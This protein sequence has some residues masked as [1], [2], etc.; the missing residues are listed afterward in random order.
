MKQFNHS[1]RACG[2][3][4]WQAWSVADLTSAENIHSQR[5]AEA[6]RYRPNGAIRYGQRY[7][8]DILWRIRK[9]ISDIWPKDCQPVTLPYRTV[10]GIHRLH[11]CL[12][13]IVRKR[14]RD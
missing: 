4:L 2:R 7:R 12:R 5:L 6:L 11:D 3:V 8:L 9:G 13:P 10:L 14:Y 1:T